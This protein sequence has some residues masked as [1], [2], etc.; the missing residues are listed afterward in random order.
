MDVVTEVLIDRARDADRLSR[1]MIVSLLLHATLLTAVTLL[2]R[3]WAAAAP[4]KERTMTISLAGAPGPVQGH[5]PIAPKPVQE[6]VPETAKP[7]AD[8]PPAL[9][10]PEMVEPVKAAKPEPKSAAKPEPKKDVPQLHG[11]TQTQG[12]EVRQGTARVDTQSSAQT[13]FGGLATGGGGTGG[14]YTDYADFCC[15]EYLQQMTRLI[16]G[17]WQQHQGQDGSNTVAF[18][19][20]RDGTITNVQIEDGPNQF[21]NLASQRALAITRQLPPLPAAFKGDHLTVHLVFQYKR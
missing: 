6:A 5:N 21:L 13:K 12:A 7:K 16:Y 17:N 1:M 2:P 8:T 18:T 9:S 3:Q 11:R 4:P 20:T 15:P 14:A 10:K 19:V